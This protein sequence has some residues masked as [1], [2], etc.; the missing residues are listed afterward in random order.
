MKSYSVQIRFLPIPSFAM[1]P[2]LSFWVYYTQ[3][4]SSTMSDTNI[5]LDSSWT[6]TCRSIS[7]CR[8]NT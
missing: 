5:R 4:H 3:R 2:Q 1:L 7:R 6:T 8:C